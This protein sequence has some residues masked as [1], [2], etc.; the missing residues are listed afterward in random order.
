MYVQGM[1]DSS[2][3]VQFT[4]LKFS[5]YNEVDTGFVDISLIDSCRSLNYRDYIIIASVTV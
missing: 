2:A 4:L 1:V 5:N 3:Q